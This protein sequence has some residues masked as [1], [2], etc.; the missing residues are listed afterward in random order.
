MGNTALS[1][2][3]CPVRRW[4]LPSSEFTRI[5]LICILSHHYRQLEF[6]F[7]SSAESA[8]THPPTASFQIV[9]RFFI[10]CGFFSHSLCYY[11]FFL[12]LFLYCHY[13]RF[14]EKT[15]MNVCIEFTSKLF[16]S[17]DNWN[18]YLFLFCLLVGW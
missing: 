10:C 12:Y 8:T 13:S 17:N 7:L 4:V 14:L 9:L 18:L 2:S 16:A 3:V 5:V 15:H 1:F 11:G 6:Y